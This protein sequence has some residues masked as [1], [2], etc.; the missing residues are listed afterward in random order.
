MNQVKKALAEELHKPVRK[1]FPRRKVE[2]RGIDETWQADLVDMQAYSKVNSGHNFLLTV[3]DNFSKFAWAVPLKNKSGREVTKALKSIL[4]KG[5]VPRK[6]HVDRGSEFYNANCKALLDSYKIKLYSTYSNLKASIVERF[7]RTIKTKMWK[8]FS[9][10]GNYKWLKILPDL[11]FEYNDTKHRTIKM[12][13]KNVNVGNESQVA[14]RFDVERWNSSKRKFKVGDKV[15]I[16]KNK[17]VFE[18]G[19][20]PNWTTEVFTVDQIK[21]TVPHTYLLKDYLGEAI[22]GGFY[23]QE[24]SKTA[25]PNDYLVEKVLRKKGNKS[26]VK[27]LGFDDTHNSWINKA[28]L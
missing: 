2:I 3:I 27:W 17:H 26:F 24:L 13:P 16:S 23:E 28:D 12:K 18:K 4:V 6:I 25:H 10:Q 1:N 15:R 21:N 5:R 14:K 7:N 19:Y 22:A 8:L 11:M 9:Y 20:T